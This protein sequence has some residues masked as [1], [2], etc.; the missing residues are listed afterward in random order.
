M[1]QTR[2]GKNVEKLILAGTPIN[3]IIQKGYSPSTVR[4]YKRK[5]FNPAKFKKDIDAIKKY[6]KKNYARKKTNTNNR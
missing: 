6:N 3:Q 2:K 1:K 4:Y 5:I